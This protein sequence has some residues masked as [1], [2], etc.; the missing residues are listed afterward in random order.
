MY[1]IFGDAVKSIPENYIVLELDTVQVES[2]EK[3]VTAYCLVNNVLPAEFPNVEQ[4][5]K[6]HRELLKQYRLQNWKFCEKSIETLTGCWGGE[7]DE[8]YSD[9]L[10]RISEFKISPPASD[11]SGVLVRAAAGSSSTDEA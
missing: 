2:A 8:F 4:N 6:V 11:W 10:K 5:I 1:I 7:L 3:P 9:L